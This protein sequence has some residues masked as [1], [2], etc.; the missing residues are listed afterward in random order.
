MTFAAEIY[1]ILRVDA[2]EMGGRETPLGRPLECRLCRFDRGYGSD[3]WSLLEWMNFSLGNLQ[4]GTAWILFQI[5]RSMM[6]SRG[7]LQ[8]IMTG[9]FIL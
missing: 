7:L 1:A 8:V 5:N 4:T 2:S 3:R 9:D 6:G